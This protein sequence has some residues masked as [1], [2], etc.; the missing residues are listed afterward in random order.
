MSPNQIHP[1][2]Q[3]CQNYHV[4][5]NVTMGDVCVTLALTLCITQDDIYHFGTM[6]CPLK[7]TLSLA[8]L[9]I[10]HSRGMGMLEKL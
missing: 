10:N 9:K 2:M 4:T 7:S 8:S 3:V 6:N 5:H 1:H